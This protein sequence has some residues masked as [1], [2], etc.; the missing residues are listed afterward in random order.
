[1]LRLGKERDEISVVSDQIGSPTYATDLAETILK[2]INNKNYIEKQQP[3][4]VYHYSNKGE[5]SWYDFAQEIFKVA[6][7]YCKVKP[8]TTE[9]YPTPARRPRNSLMS[10]N[11]IVRDLGVGKLRFE[12]SLSLFL[13]QE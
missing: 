9:Q 1:M 3:T 13:S 6:K 11:K 10:I 2:I 5:I 7:I 12:H 4:E 8:I